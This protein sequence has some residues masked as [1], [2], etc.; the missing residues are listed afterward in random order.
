MMAHACYFRYIEN[1]NKKITVQ[2]SWG[3]NVRPYPKNT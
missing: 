1:I 2:A 3:I